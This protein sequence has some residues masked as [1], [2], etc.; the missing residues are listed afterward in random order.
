[1]KNNILKTAFKKSALM[2]LAVS[3]LAVT[4][5]FAQNNPNYAPGDLLLYFTQYNGTQ[6]VL[7]NLGAAVSYR[8]ATAN[9]LNI[10][11]I[12]GTLTGSTG[13]GG[14]GYSTTWYDDPTI[15]WGL[16]GVR[17]AGTTTTTQVNG[18][19]NRTLYISAAR[20]GVG[21]AGAA[22][23]GAW[24][25]LSNGDMTTG[26]TNISSQDNRLENASVTTMLVESTG[27][28]NVD[29]QNPFNIAGQPI[30][31]FGIFPGGVMGSFSPGSFGTIGGVNAEGA[32]DLYRILATTNPSG[33]VIE[34]G[35]AAGDGS[36]QGTFVI[37]QAGSVS[38]IAPVPE[39][40][41]FSLLAASVIVGLA[42]RR[43]AQRV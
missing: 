37:T 17:S 28:S 16:A 33:T 15:F 26:A 38:Y 10:V 14:A 32:V 35:D 42:R 24:A 31:A 4:P 12:G 3:G 2:A 25:G 40:A 5:A 7:V 41:T 30:T 36:Y 43:R 19:P 11:N 22:Q 8:D 9:Q 20:T 21:T 1:M 34:T 39:P 6:T 27:T 13:S 23:S 18:D 29:N